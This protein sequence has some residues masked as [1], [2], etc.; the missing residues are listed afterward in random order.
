MGGLWGVGLWVFL[1]DWIIR[2]LVWEQLYARGG[3]RVGYVEI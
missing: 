3:I 2:V 1:D